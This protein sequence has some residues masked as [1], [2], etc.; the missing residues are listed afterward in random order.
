MSEQATLEFIRPSRVNRYLDGISPF[1]HFVY[2][3]YKQLK[4]EVLEA[5]EKYNKEYN[6][7]P[8]DDTIAIIKLWRAGLLE[9]N[10]RPIQIH[11]FNVPLKELLCAIKNGE[12]IDGINLREKI[13][14]PNFR[15][16]TNRKSESIL[17]TAFSEVIA[18]VLQ[19]NK[20]YRLNKHALE[21]SIHTRNEN[22]DE[23]AKSM[24]DIIT[25]IKEED[26]KISSYRETVKALN[27]RHV[28]TYRGGDWHIKTLQDLNKRWQELGLIPVSKPK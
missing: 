10:D 11:T 9:P 22:A 7:L 12:T 14:D 21:K 26:K 15:F 5:E 18:T 13:R 1:L 4:S 27:E 8:I 16:K 25:R 23:F 6:F 3:E 20:P 24:Y 19:S 28:S 2:E 17:S